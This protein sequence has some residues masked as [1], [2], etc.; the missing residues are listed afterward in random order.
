MSKPIP[1]SSIYLTLFVLFALNTLNF[2]DRNILSSVTQQV[3]QEF[4]LSDKQLGGLGTAFTLL[5]AAVGIPFGRWADS[6]KRTRILS[7]GVGLWSLLTMASGRAWNYWS[8]FAVRLGV[9]VGEA[10]C[11]PAATS[12]IGDLVEPKRRSAANAIFMLGL[13]AGMALSY[14]LGGVVGKAWGWRNAMLLAGIPGLIVG[15]MAWFLPEPERTEASHQGEAEGSGNWRKLLKNPIMI[16]LIASGAIHNFNMY[17]ISLFVS[18]YLQRFHGMDQAFAGNVSALSFGLGGVGIL[19]GGWICDRVALSRPAGRME[20]AGLAILLSA[21]C[22]FFAIQAPAGHYMVFALF[23]LV[24]YFL[25]CIYYPGVYAT[26]QDVTPPRQRGTAMALY[27]C[28]MY[29]LGASLGPYV[30][31]YLSDTFAL[32]VITPEEPPEILFF[33]SALGLRKAFYLLPALALALGVV[34]LW[35]GVLVGK[36]LSSKMSERPVVAE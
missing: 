13:P 14:S 25:S 2:F 34:L 12:L 30:T 11:A 3:K 10:S 17:A 29:F 27:F 36:L 5:Y 18:S 28:A 23:L 24:G 35:A 8:L 19:L 7:I 9:G 32:S 33:A 22:Y 21:P 4:D 15:L 20:V 31:G 16:L 6:G 26:I 1:K